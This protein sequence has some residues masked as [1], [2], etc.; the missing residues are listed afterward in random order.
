MYDRR[1]RVTRDDP[2]MRASGGIVFWIIV[3]VAFY[4]GV[5]MMVNS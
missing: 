2:D 1:K 3:C 4:S 5:W